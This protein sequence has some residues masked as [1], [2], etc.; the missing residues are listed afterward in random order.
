MISNVGITSIHDIIGHEAHLVVQ[1]T[2]H[3]A[4]M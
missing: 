3:N 4:H 1:T 2:V